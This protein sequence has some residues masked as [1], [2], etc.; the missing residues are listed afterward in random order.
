MFDTIVL[1]KGLARH[2]AHVALRAR[3]RWNPVLPRNRLVKE[4]R[5]PTIVV[6]GTKAE[7]NNPLQLHGVVADKVPHWHGIDI[8]LGQPCKFARQSCAKD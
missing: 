5:A 6:K 8:D 1:R 3:M 4:T 7:G 2:E